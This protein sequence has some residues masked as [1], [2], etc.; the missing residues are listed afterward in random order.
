MNRS[1]IFLIIICCFS[2]L[3]L[4]NCG[5]IGYGFS[6]L[7]EEKSSILPN[8]RLWSGSSLG[9]N[10][11]V[12]FNYDSNYQID[13]IEF[14]YGFIIIGD[15]MY[16]LERDDIE[17]GVFIDGLRF[18]SSSKDDMALSKMREPIILESDSNT[19]IFQYSFYFNK[20]FNNDE[21]AEIVNRY[22]KENN[23]LK[24]YVKYNLYINNEI[25]ENEFSNEY[26]FSIQKLRYLPLPILFQFILVEIFG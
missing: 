9:Y 10:F 11:R 25:I 19:Q 3:C 20:T 15:Y 21:I 12:S 18:F 8:V 23:Y 22:S 5:T 17:I 26:T 13:N 2:I 16:V 14:D 1:I 24:V 7:Y 6:I 4:N